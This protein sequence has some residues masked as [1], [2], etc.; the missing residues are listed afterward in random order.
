MTALALVPGMLIVLGAF[1][2]VLAFRPEFVRL[3]DALAAL[4]S[5]APQDPTPGAAPRGER[6][7]AWWLRRR[8]VVVSAVTERALELKGRS[9]ARHYSLKLGAAGL[10]F[11]L[12]LAVGVA[13]VA[14][15]RPT[16][17]PLLI[18]LLGAV[19]GF[20]LPDVALRGQ[21][22]DLTSDATE[23]LLTFFDLVTL[24][25]LANQSATQ[26]LHAAATL[27]DNTVF[28]HVRAALERARLEQRMPYAELKL[29]GQR[30]ELPA[31]V[32]LADVMRLD[33]SGAALSGT[34]RARVRELRD[35]H[36]TEVKMAANRVSERMTIFMA[37]PSLLFGLIFLVPP[38]L[39]L[40]SR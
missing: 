35:A 26:S 2:A 40:I 5:E 6:W 32:D 24:E 23:S 18:S 7:G 33:E 22:G 8:P 36:L 10:G 21:G 15:G 30:L 27:S 25:R 37:I 3:D 28:A 19:V 29:L 12:P 1:W 17:L 4:G 39:T 31:L 13:A 38:I 20:V 16:P 14:L 34:L 11:G 9:L